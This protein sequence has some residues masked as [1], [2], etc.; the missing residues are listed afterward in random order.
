MTHNIQVLSETDNPLLRRKDVV[1]RVFHTGEK[2]P[3]RLEI[4]KLLAAHYNKPPEQTFIF[5][6]VTRFGIAACTVHARIYETPEDAQEIEYAYVKK[7]N[8]KPTAEESGE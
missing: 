8:S 2:T 3:A 1:I 4:Q 6:Q 7:R 5:K